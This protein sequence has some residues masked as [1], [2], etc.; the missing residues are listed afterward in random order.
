MIWDSHPLAL[1]ATPKQV[2]IDGIT[3][4]ENPFTVEKPFTF[5]SLP[6]IPDFEKE[7]KAAIKYQGLPPL[8]TS[9]AKADTIVFTNVGSVYQRSWPGIREV[10]SIRDDGPGVVVVQNGEISC[11]GSQQA[12][13]GSIKS[14]DETFESFDLQGGAIW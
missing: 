2:W 7:V 10:S 14:S 11:F 4:L 1:G 13:L 8:S 3:Q 5:Q 6:S 12:C 9:L